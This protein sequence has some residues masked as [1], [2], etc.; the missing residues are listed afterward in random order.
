MLGDAW[1]FDNRKGECATGQ[2]V[3][4]ADCEGVGARIFPVDRLEASVRLVGTT[5]VL[6]IFSMNGNQARPGDGEGGG[7]AFTFF[8]SSRLVWDSCDVRGRLTVSFKLELITEPARLEMHT[9]GISWLATT[10]DLR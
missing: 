1:L 6:A 2:A 8:K 5:P 9:I 10:G 7:M 4:I 3:T